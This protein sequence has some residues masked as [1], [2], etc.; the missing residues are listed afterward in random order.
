VH[1]D[2]AYLIDLCDEVVGEPALREHELP[3]LREGGEPDG[4][5]VRVDAWYPYALLIVLV[6]DRRRDEEARRLAL[7]AGAY[8]VDIVEVPRGLLERD[9]TGAV[10]RRPQDI[11]QI[12][13]LIGNDEVRSMNRVEPELGGAVYGMNVA[14]V[15]EGVWAED[16]EAWDEEDWDEDDGLVE[17]RDPLPVDRDAALGWRGR[18]VALAIL[19]A[20]KLA[21]RAFAVERTG[22]GLSQHAFEVLL[23][24]LVGGSET[25]E[26]D[27]IAQLLDRRPDQ[28]EPAL[29]ELRAAGYAEVLG[30]AHEDDDWDWTL[31][32]EGRDVAVAWI[33]RTLPLFA[34]WPSD[35]PGVDDAGGPAD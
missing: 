24:L 28:V 17:P 15:D 3:W 11:D 18:A 27:E 4:A 14:M 23:V 20:V 35:V 32:D 29:D 2:A 5:P 25:F 12:R 22:H 26:P 8:G 6:V 13:A 31:T 33:A 30:A 21:R 16:V 34:G 7:A 9:A 19:E 1:D 10:R